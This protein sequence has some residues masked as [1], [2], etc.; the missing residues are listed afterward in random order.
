MVLR[1]IIYS[2]GVFVLLTVISLVIVVIMRLL[3]GIVHKE[4]KVVEEKK[5]E[6]NVATH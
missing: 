4:K 2:V 6:A 3:Y 1:A 5:V